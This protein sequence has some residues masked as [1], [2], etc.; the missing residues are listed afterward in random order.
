MYTIILFICLIFN[1]SNDYVEPQSAKACI[2]ESYS[3]TTGVLT[4]T[5]GNTYE[6]HPDTNPPKNRSISKGDSLF[7]T[8]IERVVNNRTVKYWKSIAKEVK[9]VPIR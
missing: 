6:P 4:C 1:F 9:I 5:D 3:K 8:Y 2:A 7:V